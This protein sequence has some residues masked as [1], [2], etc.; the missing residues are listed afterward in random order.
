[1][2]HVHFNLFSTFFNISF[3]K[4]IQI[5][6]TA[7]YRSL[8]LR[9]LSKALNRLQCTVSSQVLINAHKEAIFNNLLEF[10]IQTPEKWFLILKWFRWLSKCFVIQLFILMGMNSCQMGRKC[11]VAVRA[12]LVLAHILDCNSIHIISRT[13]RKIIIP[14]KWFL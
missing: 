9:G 4:S 8:H 13:V 2:S 3:N 5:N 11:E 12:E 1:M 14:K 7:K 10:V 6:I